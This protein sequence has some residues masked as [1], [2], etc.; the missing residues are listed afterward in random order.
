MHTSAQQQLRNPLPG[1]SLWGDDNDS[2]DLAAAAPASSGSAEVPEVVCTGTLTR[3]AEVRVKP[4]GPQ[5][6][7]V[8]VVCI[9]LADVTPMAQ[10]VH[11]ER[12]F[13][14]RPKADAFA[15]QLRKGMRITAHCPMQHTRLSLTNAQHIDFQP[16]IHPGK[17]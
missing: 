8:I 4:V 9:D 12:E 15:A 16:L 6:D 13:P 1:T 7:P 10:A 3:D 11:V 5:G 17:P 2:Q 14:T